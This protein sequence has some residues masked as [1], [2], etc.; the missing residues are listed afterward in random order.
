MCG[1]YQSLRHK[2]MLITMACSISLE[3]ETECS[4][5]SELPNYV[6]VLILGQL[7]HGL[8]G[9]TLYT[10]GIGLIDD[11]VPANASPMYIGNPVCLLIAHT[12]RF[13]GNN[14][15]SYT[16]ISTV[17]VKIGLIDRSVPIHRLITISLITQAAWLRGNNSH[18]YGIG[19]INDFV[20]AITAPMYI[21]Q[22]LFD[23]SDFL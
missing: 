20:L 19:I 13:R 23:Y 1:K 9:T 12:A 2:Y 4:K 10:V 3:V 22:A 17:T 7:L 18:T 21:V 11:S 5:D 15:V 14:S 6:Y 8:G 16:S